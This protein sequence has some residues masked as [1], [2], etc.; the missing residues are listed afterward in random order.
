MIQRN[1]SGIGDILEQTRS[2][3]KTWCPSPEDP[4]ELWFRGQSRAR[5]GLLPT[6]YRPAALGH[7]DESSIFEIFKSWGT[8]YVSRLPRDDWE[9]YFLA[10]HHSLPSRLLDWTGSLFI[11]IYFALWDQ[12]SGRS[13]IEIATEAEQPEGPARYDDDSPTIWVLD[14]GTLNRCVLGE[15]MDRVLIP[16]GSRTERYLPDALEKLKDPDN[17]LPLAL[18]PPR[19]SERITAQQGVF[20]LHGHG[21]K[22][23][24][25]VATESSADCPIRL[26]RV[27]LNRTTIARTWQDLHTA[28]VGQLS[29]FPDL[30]GVAK[31]ISWVYHGVP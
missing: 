23:L 5:W 19:I 2:I 17:E 22:P 28:G 14:A 20:T 27:L 6:L 25:Q 3:A 21:V 24:D 9:W 15:R 16:G 8:P 11:A 1:A 12:V 18:L 29:V 26:G 13:R 10:R 30:D 4:E 7:Y 31:H